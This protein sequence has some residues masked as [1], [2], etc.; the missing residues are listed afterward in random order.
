MIHTELIE[1]GQ[2]KSTV[3]K[4]KEQI[5]VLT[6]LV[7]QEQAKTEAI[8]KDMSKLALDFTQKLALNS[9]IYDQQTNHLS[10]GEV[11]AYGGFHPRAKTNQTTKRVKGINQRKGSDSISSA[12]NLV[13]MNTKASSSGTAQNFYRGAMSQ[14]QNFRM[15]ED[16]ISHSLE[17]TIKMNEQLANV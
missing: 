8:Q 3:E 4:V 10:S 7:R 12:L 9:A 6:H 2:S 17:H 11:T 5:R 1:L 16:K 15:G 13:V 14:K